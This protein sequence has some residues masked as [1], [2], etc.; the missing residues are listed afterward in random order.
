[1][2]VSRF[3][4]TLPLA[5]AVLSLASLSCGDRHELAT[6][7]TLAVDSPST[8]AGILAPPPGTQPGFY[9]LATGN[10][11]SYTQE[12]VLQLVDVPD[13]P[14]PEQYVSSI[15]IEILLPTT[16]DGREYLGELTTS[17][18]SQRYAPVRQDAT[19][20]YEWSPVAPNEGGASPQPMRR[21][22]APAGRSPAENAALELAARRLEEKIAAVE[23]LLGRRAAA[24]FQ[25]SFPPTRTQSE[26]TRL[27]Y[28]LESKSEW[29]IRQ[30][31]RF[32]SSARVIG[33]ET[34]QLPPG[35]LTGYRVAMISDALGRSDSVTWWYGSTGLL[36]EVQHFEFQATDASGNLVGRYLYDV[37][38][39]LTS[40]E[41]PPPHDVP[42]WPPR[43][44]K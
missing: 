29:R 36:Q 22:A 34:L 4:G 3:P 14:P 26:V 9:P 1:M 10:H 43:R 33:Q 28:P 25:M 27:Q 6:R 41:I 5:A 39:W 11:W 42:P 13:P 19:G 2:R 32:N 8:N 23:A 31:R 21:I 16:V 18:G 12:V 7:P 24:G 15:G 40:Y 44:P 37:R 38:Q 30:D 20:L 17:E 35:A